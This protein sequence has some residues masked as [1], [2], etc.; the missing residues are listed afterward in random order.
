MSL[1]GLLQSSCPW[2]VGTIVTILGL[3]GIFLALRLLLLSVAYCIDAVGT[4]I[5][6]VK[7][8]VLTWKSPPNDTKL[9]RDAKEKHRLLD[10]GRC[11]LKSLFNIK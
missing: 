1:I 6:A 5:R 9:D 10:V 3:V 2:A 4:V 7:R 11:L 8:V